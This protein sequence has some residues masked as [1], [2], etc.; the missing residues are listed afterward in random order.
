MNRS[1]ATAAAGAAG[2][3]VLVGALAGGYELGRGHVVTHT[4]TATVTR[5]ATVTASPPPARRRH[6][7]P[8][9]VAATSAPP[10]PSAVIYDC[11]SHP[12]S[13]PSEI[14]LTCADAGIGVKNL[15]WSGWGHATATASGNAW[16]NNCNPDCAQGTYV[17]TA[18]TVTVSAL[19]GGR[20]TYMQISDPQQSDIS[21]GYALTTSGQ[22]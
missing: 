10:A 11:L 5:T 17:Y 3:L 12:V 16:Q 8:A 18:A 13:A 19:S 15:T 4:V 6:P 1:A 22:P 9:P 20:Y 14:I 2:A 21:H 7:H